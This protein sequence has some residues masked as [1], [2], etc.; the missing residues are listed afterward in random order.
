MIEDGDVLELPGGGRA[1]AKSDAVPIA[2]LLHRTSEGAGPDLAALIADRVD[3][4]SFRPRLADDIERKTFPQRWGTEYEMLAN[5]RDLLHLRLD[6]E[7]AEQTRLMDGTRTVKEILVERLGVTGGLELDDV[8][9]IVDEL[10]RNGFLDHRFVDVEAGAR[11]ALHPPR[12]RTRAVH[13]LRTLRFEWAGADRPVRWMHRYGLRWLFLP[14]SVWAGMAVAFVGLGFFLATAADHRFGLSG[15]DLAYGFVLL[16]LLNVLLTMVHELGHAV[17][18]VHFGRRVKSAGVMIYFGSPAFFVESSDGLMLDRWQRIAQ[19][20]AGPWAELV[21]AGA[22]SIVVGLWPEWFLAPLLYKF[23]VLNYLVITMNLVPLLELDGYW[24]FADLVQVPDLRPM[25][26]AFVRRDLWHKLRTRSR[27]SGQDLALCIYGTLGV[28]FAIFSLFTAFFFWREVFGDFVSEM[29]HE[30]AWTRV[31]LLVLAALLLGPLLQALVQGAR[32]VGRA[33]RGAWRAATFRLQRSWRV[34]AATMIDA[35]RLFDD[36][37][38]EVLS[39]IA[40]HVRL[41]SLARRQPVFRQGDPPTAFFV[42]RRGSVQIVEEDPLTGTDRVLRTVAKGDS[43]GELGLLDGAPRS[44]TARAVG[45]V[46]L[47]E[48]ARGVFDAL[49]ADR[50][51]AERFA[52]TVAQAWELRGLPCFAALSDD[53]LATLLG[54]GRWLTLGP[55]AVLMREGEPGDAFWV[56][57]SGQ[58]RVRAGGRGVATLGAGSYVGEKAL[59]ADAARTA[60]VEAVTPVRAFR[61][62]RKGFDRLVAGAFRSGALREHDG[63]HGDHLGGDTVS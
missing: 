16:L 5:P 15:G 59:L 40:G 25:S 49:L 19:S 31:L 14:V 46:E 39:E 10:R 43:F 26:L 51:T 8:L 18:L 50:A 27:L 1:Y 38:E 53:Q 56:I 9:D 44:A 17:T 34:E 57:G 33:M 52:P 21:V 20:F 61:L 58:V 29:W 48:V 32:A 28:A 2:S 37:P 62:P 45:G 42:V 41:R 3:P 4:G 54:D 63:P 12:L 11:R 22:V 13:L 30:S 47:Y 6:P 55:D 36:L 60:T 23:A 35:L 7:S 24:I